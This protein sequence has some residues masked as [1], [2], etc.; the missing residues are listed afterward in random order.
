MRVIITVKH[1]AVIVH[2]SFIPKTLVVCSI[3]YIIDETVHFAYD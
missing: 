3:A 1:P 2:H